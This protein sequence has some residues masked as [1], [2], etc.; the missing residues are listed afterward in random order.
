MRRARHC[1]AGAV[2]VSE[3]E[4]RVPSR[5]MHLSEKAEIQI[6][7]T[8]AL[9]LL[10]FSLHKILNLY[11]IFLYASGR[12][13]EKEP[14]WHYELFRFSHKGQFSEGLHALGVKIRET[15][16]RY[17]TKIS[18]QKQVNLFSVLSY[19]THEI[20]IIAFV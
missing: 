16:L 12:R 1:A 2:V 17:C 6:P 20:K 9:R 18:C 4:C 13:Q 3:N 11:N 8:A 15:F 10:S 14:F 5:Q 7:S 19:I